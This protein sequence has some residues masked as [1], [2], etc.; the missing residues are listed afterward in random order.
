MCFSKDTVQGIELIQD[1]QKQLKELREETDVWH[2]IWY[3]LAVDMAEQVETESLQ[4]HIGVRSKQNER[5]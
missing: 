3:E 5:K 4:F 1:V 2:K